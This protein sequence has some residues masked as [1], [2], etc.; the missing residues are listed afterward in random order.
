MNW[1]IVHLFIN[2][3]IQ[4]SMGWASIAQNMAAV[5]KKEEEE[6]IF[7]TSEEISCVFDSDLDC[8]EGCSS[9]VELANSVHVI[10]SLNSELDILKV[11]MRDRVSFLSRWVLFWIKFRGWI[12]C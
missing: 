3:L 5:S 9:N 7:D 12:A 1:S 11:L 6:Q 8:S 10:H 4:K 2:I